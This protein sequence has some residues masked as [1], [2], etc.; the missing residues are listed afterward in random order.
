MMDRI[1][2]ELSMAKTHC[3]KDSYEFAKRWINA[4]D[5]YEYTGFP[6]RG[7]INNIFNPY[8]VFT[9]VF[10]HLILKKNYS[11]IYSLLSFMIDLYKGLPLIKFTASSREKTKDGKTIFKKSRSET[12]LLNIQRKYFKR[13]SLHYFSLKYIFGM[14]GHEQI[15]IF[16][17]R[18]NISDYAFS[19]LCQIDR[20][21]T[22][23]DAGLAEELMRRLSDFQE[24]GFKT[25]QV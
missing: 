8:L 22:V 25:R 23:F 19:A 3:S 9:I 13:L 1:G 4:R 17:S 7:I 16:L 14:L 11:P 5:G 24:I 12:V 20:I 10:D 2:V 21:S 15:R 18:L 6:I